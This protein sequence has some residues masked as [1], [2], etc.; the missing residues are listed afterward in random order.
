MLVQLSHSSH[1]CFESISYLQYGVHCYPSCH[2]ARVTQPLSLVYLPRRR[3]T[4][5]GS[6][7][8]LQCGGRGA[9]IAAHPILRCASTLKGITPSPIWGTWCP[10]QDSPWYS[11]LPN[12]KLKVFNCLQNSLLFFTMCSIRLII[13]RLQIFTNPYICLRVSILE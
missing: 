6:A 5:K 10:H 1:A 3:H 2:M 13:I 7:Q 8:F 12:P 9:T 11:F 4:P